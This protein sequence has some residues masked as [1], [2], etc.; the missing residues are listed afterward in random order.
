MTSLK[1]LFLKA[2][3]IS[4][5]TY[6][7]F[8]N[9]KELELLDISDNKLGFIDLQMFSGMKKSKT[10][11]IV[12][13]DNP[14]SCSYLG[15]IIESMSA[16]GINVKAVN[17]VKNSSNIFG[18]GCESEDHKSILKLNSEV[19]D[20]VSTKLNELIDEVNKIKINVNNFNVDVDVLRSE[21]FNFRN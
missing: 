18:V 19:D 10:I 5:I 17:V 13:L 20:K 14:W 15:K 4:K 3:G 1:K 21:M 16:Q 8:S 9:Q 12:R 7:T 6:G 2:T 11:D